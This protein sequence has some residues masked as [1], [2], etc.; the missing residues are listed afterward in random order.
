MAAAIPSA[1]RTSPDDCYCTEPGCGFQAPPRALLDHLVAVHS[2]RAARISYGDQYEL[3]VPASERR[4]LLLAEKDERVFLLAVG[5]AHGWG[6]S[7]SSADGDENRA[8]KAISVLCLRANAAAEAGPQYVTELSTAGETMSTESA[9][10]SSPGPC[11][12]PL[13]SIL[14]ATLHGAS[15]D[16]HLRVR[17]SVAKKSRFWKK[18][19]H[20]CKFGFLG[21]LCCCVKV[22][23]TGN[24]VTYVSCI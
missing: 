24:S 18:F 22:Y 8:F 11:E 19:R 1:T 4:I 10:W 15:K 12:A 21:R 14:P 13:K 23:R 7:V 9:V 2:L 16:V 5:D 3:V 20:S 6:P 17:I